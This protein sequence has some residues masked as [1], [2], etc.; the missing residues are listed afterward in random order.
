MLVEFHSTTFPLR[1]TM[2]GRRQL[3][4]YQVGRTVYSVVR[5]RGLSTFQTLCALSDNPSN[6]T[7]LSLGQIFIGEPLTQQP[8]SNK[9][10][11]NFNSLSGGKSTNNNYSSSSRTNQLITSKPIFIKATCWDTGLFTTRPLCA[12]SSGSLNPTFNSWTF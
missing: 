7:Y 10:N 4:K 8:T 9:T 11:V 2:E 6:P 12:L 5:D 1:R 3:K